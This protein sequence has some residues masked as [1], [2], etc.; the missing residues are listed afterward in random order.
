MDDSEL[1]IVEQYGSI[2]ALRNLTAGRRRLQSLPV[3]E[4]YLRCT[5]SGP[6]PLIP[7]CV[8]TRKLR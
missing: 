3:H 1:Q 7:D 6:F 8:P 5:L 2:C 4:R